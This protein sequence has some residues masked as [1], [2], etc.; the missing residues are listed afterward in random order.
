MMTYLNKKQKI[1]KKHFNGVI[2]CSTYHHILHMLLL[3]TENKVTIFFVP[4]NSVSLHTARK[5]LFIYLLTYLPCP[6]LVETAL[7]RRRFYNKP[8]DF[9]ERDWIEFGECILSASVR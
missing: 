4:T 8:N 9:I 7:L 5:Y 1:N 2:V 6:S 3:K